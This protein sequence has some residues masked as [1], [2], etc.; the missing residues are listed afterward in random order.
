[1]MN[2]NAKNAKPMTDNEQKE[3]T[4]RNVLNAS[5]QHIKCEVW[6]EWNQ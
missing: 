5:L 3:R 6:S 1:M 4:L 2:F